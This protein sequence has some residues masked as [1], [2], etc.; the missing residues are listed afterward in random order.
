MKNKIV[1][2]LIFIMLASA[3]SLPRQGPP[4]PLP[5]E[6]LPAAASPFPTLPPSASAT[7]TETPA[8]TPTTLPSD[9]PFSIDCTALPASRQS[10]C[11]AFITATRDQ[12]YPILRQVTGVSLSKC[13]PG[14]HYIIL[15]T[16][17][18]PGAGGESGGDTISLNEQYS[19]D[20]PHSYDVHE[21]LHSISTCARAL[22]THVFHGMILNYA[23]DRLGV[24]DPGYF[25]DRSAEDLTTILDS[26]LDQVKT[27][28]GQ[29]LKNL[30]IGILQRKTTIAYFDLGGQAIQKLYRSTLYPPKISASP[31][32][33]LVSV[34]AGQAG[35]VQALL[36]TLQQDYQYRLDVPACG[37]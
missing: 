34:W 13:Y 19:I 8:P 14:M 32:P 16:D 28:S 5:T 35:Q 22:D 23:Y 2:I 18:A 20:L 7:W 21:L 30:C 12:V 15:A 37:Y 6:P 17:P 26:Q 10:D 4:A 31:S 3:C 24:H 27:A 29:D 25:T 11:A 9:L 33:K 1:P 36:E